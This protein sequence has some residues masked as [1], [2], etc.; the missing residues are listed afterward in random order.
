VK[1]APCLLLVL[2]SLAD[3]SQCILPWPVCCPIDIASYGTRYNT[4]NNNNTLRGLLVLARFGFCVATVVSDRQ[5]TTR[6]PDL[7][8]YILYWRCYPSSTILLLC[9]SLFYITNNKYQCDACLVT[10]VFWRMSKRIFAHGV[11]FRIWKLANK[12]TRTLACR[13]ARS[14]ISCL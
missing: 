10:G 4:F 6:R 3:V 8:K 13:R 7:P 12:K 11:Q 9:S 2:F 14:L 1:L 5:N